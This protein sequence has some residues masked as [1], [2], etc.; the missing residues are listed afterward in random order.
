MLIGWVDDGETILVEFEM[1][2]EQRQNA[3]ADGAKADQDDRAG[4]FAVNGP[5]RHLAAS[6]QALENL[7]SALK[8][9]RGVLIK[10]RRGGSGR[11]AI[12]F[13]WI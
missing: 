8:A 3:P 11:G 5:V 1:P 13:K 12:L 6:P 10:C 4:D 9:G 7:C 2:F